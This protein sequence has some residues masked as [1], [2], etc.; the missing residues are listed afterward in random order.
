[1]KQ[2]T[3]K[4][5]VALLLM[6][7]AA[8]NANAQRKDAYAWYDKSNNTLTFYYDSNYNSREGGVVF[9]DDEMEGVVASIY[10]VY[11]NSQTTICIEKAVIDA[12]FADFRP[13]TTAFWFAIEV[14]DGQY[15]TDIQQI[16]GLENLNTSEVVSMEGMFAGCVQL[17]SLD[18]SGWDTSNVEIMSEMFSCCE[19]LKTIYV[20]DKWDTYWVWES[21]SMFENCTSLVGGA[22]TVFD[23]SH[24]DQE[25]A[26]VD[27]GPDNPGY[28]TMKGVPTGIDAQRLN[29]N[30]QM[31]GEVQHFGVDGTRLYGQ[32]RGLNMVRQADGTVKKVLVK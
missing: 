22:G 14:A 25:Y 8:V 32:R 10:Y 21:S 15:L 3:I 24:I 5:L 31:A 20:G 9:I 23:S 12:S 16:V 28:F 7:M 26:H 17:T 13:K 2:T 6:L 29:E 18:L 19:N 27:G 11:Y 4:H 30:G 1:M